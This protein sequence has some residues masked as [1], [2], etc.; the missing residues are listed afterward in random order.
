[1]DELHIVGDPSRGGRL[2]L[3]LTKLRH[4]ALVAERR[5]SGSSPSQSARES[6]LRRTQLVGMSA[7]LGNLE[8]IANWLGATA[9]R[10]LERPIPLRHFLRV[11]V[12]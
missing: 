10:S 12:A 8:A 7:T 1:M 4:N 9:Y 11:R 5:T 6:R 2:E 3:L